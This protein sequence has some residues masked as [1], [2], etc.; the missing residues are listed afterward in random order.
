VPVNVLYIHHDGQ[1]AGSAI[2]LRNL[3][4]S[5]DRDVFQ[6]HI[7]LGA[8]GP[9]RNFY[10]DL[11]IP[12]DVVPIQFYGTCP[13]AHW[14][15][16]GYYMNWRALF[17]APKL[18]EYLQDKQPD[19]VHINDKSMLTAGLVA[20]NQGFPIVWHLRSSYNI[21]HSNF[22]AWVS[23]Q[24]IRSK[25]A[26]LIAISEDECDG[27]EDLQNL[28]I[29]YNSVDFSAADDAITLRQQTRV[30]LG[31]EQKEIVI[32]MV[33][34]LSKIRG[35]WDFIEIAGLVQEKLPE[36]TLRFVILASIPGRAPHVLGLWESLGFFDTT[37]PEDKTWQLAQQ[38]GID[39]RLLITGYRP[40]PLSVI[41]AMDILVSCSHFGVMGRPPF[42]AMAVRVP[43]AAWAGHSR[44]SQVIVNEKNA[45]V[46]SRWNRPALANAIVR[47]VNDS[48]LRDKMGQQGQQYSRLHFNPFQNT[49]KVE[50]IYRDVM[51]KK[52]NLHSHKLQGASNETYTK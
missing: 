27:F 7:L 18:A 2:S 30:S 44:K 29:V 33:G 38:A 8:E 36:T 32:G 50:Q 23:R 37:H 42:E 20:S 26:H 1:L 4:L 46:V 3:L 17:P 16:L 10:E 24:I 28:S 48:G 40:D 49:K 43:V 9:A 6:P 22:Q 35:T 51:K 45:L 25:A 39:K 13:G 15:Q 5:L 41:A 34:H 52:S 31:I 12:V 19:I 11:H 21:S 47:L 14:F